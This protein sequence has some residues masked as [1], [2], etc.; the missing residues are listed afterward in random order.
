V[1][2]VC[3]FHPGVGHLSTCRNL[4]IYSVQGKKDSEW[5]VRTGHERIECLEKLG[6]DHIYR[7]LS[8]GHLPFGGEFR[9]ISKWFGKQRRDLYARELVRARLPPDETERWYW[10]KTP[11][12]ARATIALRSSTS[13][14]PTTARACSLRVD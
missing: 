5:I 7:E 4:P 13:A 2:F 6:Y 3:A 12:L 11:L 10:I 1:P 9:R 8:G 14:R